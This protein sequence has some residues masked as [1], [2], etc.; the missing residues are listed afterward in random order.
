MGFFKNLFKITPQSFTPANIIRTVV[1]PQV[2]LYTGGLSIAKPQIN[3]VVLASSDTNTAGIL[4]S[5]YVGASSLG[6]VQ[7]GD[8]NVP[9]TGINNVANKFG[10]TVA[11]LSLGSAASNVL[12]TSNAI[13][14][15]AYGPPAPLSATQTVGNVL[16]GA[17]STS[18]TAYAS[19]QAVPV[20]IQ[21]FGRQTGSAILQLL[22][23]NF[24]GAIDTLTADSPSTNVSPNAPNL[25]GSY[26]NGGGSGGSGLGIAANTGQSQS[27]SLVYP[28]LGLA[29]IVLLLVFVRKK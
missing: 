3:G 4:D 14:P 8:P 18:S 9:T 20:V 11:A 17:A 13:A 26:N 19:S 2:A 23:G 29:A 25:Y 24:K 22:S 27:S 21:I 10:A 5:A 1:A 12:S 6:R 16:A 7:A 15:G 28:V